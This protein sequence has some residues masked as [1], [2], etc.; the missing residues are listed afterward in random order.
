MAMKA[1]KTRF[2][3]YGGRAGRSSGGAAGIGSTRILT[4]SA[5]NFKAVFDFDTTPAAYTNGHKPGT[6]ADTVGDS[7]SE[8]CV[9]A[10]GIGLTY[11]LDH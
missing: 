8:K 11:D 1:R 3:L 9:T 5:S 2:P 4:P 10:E 6:R 7:K